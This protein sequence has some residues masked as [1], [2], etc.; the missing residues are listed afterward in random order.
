M[1]FIARCGDCPEWERLT[2]EERAY[3]IWRFLLGHAINCA[4]GETLMPGTLHALRGYHYPRLEFALNTRDEM[5]EMAR[6]WGLDPDTIPGA[7][8]L[9]P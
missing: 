9:L 5:R 4:R 1:R 2:P 6:A 3:S 8:S 7:F